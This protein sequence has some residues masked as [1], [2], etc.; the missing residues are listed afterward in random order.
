MSKNKINKINKINEIKNLPKNLTKNEFDEINECD[1]GKNLYRYHDSSNNIYFAKC[2]YVKEEYDIKK[3][4]S[5]NCFII[6][7]MVFYIIV[8]SLVRHYSQ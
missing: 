5:Y 1:C 4:L 3:I 2:A 7:C 8:V 6:V